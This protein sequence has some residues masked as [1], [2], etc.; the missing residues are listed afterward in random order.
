[1]FGCAQAGG[2]GQYVELE[3]D[4]QDGVGVFIGRQLAQPQIAALFDVLAGDEVD[5]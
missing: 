5:R 3:L 2:V 1:M 4:H